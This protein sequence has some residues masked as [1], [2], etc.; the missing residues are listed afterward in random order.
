[1][2]V[3]PPTEVQAS[4]VQSGGLQQQQVEATNEIISQNEPMTRRKFKE[5]TET[6]IHQQGVQ[7]KRRKKNDLSLKEGSNL[8]EH[9]V[10][11]ER[12]KMQASSNSRSVQKKDTTTDAA[13][14]RLLSAGRAKNP[15]R[16][17]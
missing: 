2:E 3:R 16:G 17:K 7:A 13:L 10:H 5:V 14:Q 1:M 9:G 4:N 12:P 15:N 6:L 8:N 11:E